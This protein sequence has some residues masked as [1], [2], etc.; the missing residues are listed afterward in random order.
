VFD[1]GAV[2]ENGRE[3]EARSRSSQTELGEVEVS[4]AIVEVAALP[5][6]LSLVTDLR[7]T[8][9]KAS[10]LQEEALVSLTRANSVDGEGGSSAGTDKLMSRM[11]NLR[12][13]ALEETQRRQDSVQ[14]VQRRRKAAQ[15]FDGPAFPSIDG[16]MACFTFLAVIS[17]LIAFPLFTLQNWRWR[18]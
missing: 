5:R 6:L 10:K 12:K 7:D 11:L 14:S 3:E 2:S 1:A 4:F 15:S 18:Q 17:D 16:R 8:V 9:T 13:S